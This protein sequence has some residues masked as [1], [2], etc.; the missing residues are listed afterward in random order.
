MNALG[1]DWISVLLIAFTHFLVATDRAFSKKIRREFQVALCMC[2]VLAILDNSYLN[3][4]A[5]TGN[6]L[7]LLIAGFGAFARTVALAL[8][9]A[10]VTPYKKFVNY[11][12]Y[13][14]AVINFVL[15]CCGFILPCVISSFVYAICI[16]VFLFIDKSKRE[17]SDIVLSAFFGLT[18]VLAF[19]VEKEYDNK[20]VVN[21]C[22]TSLICIYYYYLVMKTYKKDRLTG[23]LI[24]HNLT[25]E[26]EDNF[27]RPYDLVLIDVDN[28]KLI[29]DKY[30]HDKGD[31]VLVTIVKTTLKHL[32]RGC[33]MY[34]FG[35][36]EF[37]IISRKVST[38]V[39]REA[40]EASNTELAEDDYRMS[41][42]IVKHEPGDDS[43][44]T[45]VN[46]DKAMYEN[47]RLIKSE[48]IWDDMT[49]LYNLRGF[50][51][52]LE[53]FRKSSAKENHSVCLVGVDVERLSNINKDYGYTE[54]NL[55]ITVLA[56]ALKSCLRGRDFIGHLGSDEFVVAIE[57][58]NE[59]DDYIVSFISQLQEMV[60]NSFELSSKEYFV[61]LN[62]DR[63]FIEIDSKIS[64][65]VHV[66]NLLYIKQ[67]E[68]DNRRKNDI[69]ETEKEYNEEEDA[70]VQSILDNNKL[71]YAFQPIVSARDGQ[72]LGYESLM[73]SDTET[74]VSPLTILKYADRSKRSYDVEK[75]TMF[76]TLAKF[77]ACT[78]I[79]EN[80]RIFVNAIPGHLLSD[81]DFELLKSKYGYLMGR[82]VVEITEQREIDDDSLARLNTRREKGGFNIAIDDYGSGVSNTNN[83]LRY[84]P[85]VV[86][87]DRLLITGIDRNAKKQ[88]F[89]KSIIAFAQ[90][91][92]MYTL[93]EGVETESELKAVIRLGVDLIQGY[94]AAKP[95]IDIIT[96]IPDNIRK[97][98]IKENL[99]AGENQ[100]MVYTAS[101]SCE[102][103]VV[104][105]AMEDY[106]QINVSAE[107]VTISGSSEFTADMIIKIKE[108]TDCH[109]TL[110]DVKLSSV[111]G[112]PC[113]E[114]EENVNLTLNIEGSCKLKI[115]GIHVP[116]S[117][118][119]KII[120]G[121]TLTIDAKGHEC[122]AIGT[123]TQTPFGL[124]ELRSS[125]LVTVNID[126]E[127][128]TGIGG[129]IKGSNSAIS[130]TSG[131]VNLN[132][133]GVNAVGI[134]AH[135]GDVPIRICNTDMNNVFRANSGTVIGTLE[136]NQDIVFENFS[137]EFN[138]SGT[139]ISVIGTTG[140]A[141]GK[142]RLYAG[143]IK[144][145]FSGHNVVFIGGAEGD[146]DIDISHCS[147]ITH[148]EGD[149]ISGFG[150]RS[151]EA[152]LSIIE[153]SVDLTINASSPYAIGAKEKNVKFIGP[154]KNFDINGVES[155]I[156]AYV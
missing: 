74:M 60:D 43:S 25:F 48:D 58:D 11:F 24:R 123:D 18:F 151:Q 75:L 93:A 15:I 140:A 135:K 100:R 109:L 66:N 57:C 2:L 134:G 154:S 41:Y 131:T 116:E 148:G 30:G 68:K 122:F 145:K 36:D 5:E 26:L 138:G 103:S 80:V 49:G 132:V 33:R 85:Q 31:E 144:S 13:I 65:E 17:V 121:G 117:S 110:S 19:V 128:C 47:K 97:L 71:Q 55:I 98:I 83:L 114:L 10:I 136:G 91:N 104:Q 141:T 147:I 119:I 56:K 51:D 39:L 79:P 6:N 94:V 101:E 4:A 86:K 50:L 107:N 9:A 42:G 146:I 142:V 82:M 76:N 63:Y 22:L 124:I 153:C 137:I 150:T 102:L 40:I 46:A 84:M 156:F 106:T 1:F 127:E 72:I 35:G 92:D 115:K 89:V 21:G 28:F 90:E 149:N 52:E 112:R 45:I 152:I 143:S 77:A 44:V 32:P 8:L 29:N 23:L 130:L 62:I 78:E 34:R 53:S 59:E 14:P 7:F 20:T 126:G 73:R 81:V 38:E 96:E 67:D 61:K 16:I 70:L 87:I 155:D 133:A 108:N 54:G 113:I 118:S 88:F 129:G 37:I 95:S 105:L 27:N 111:D 139:N 64:S 99:K 120:G 125:G 3:S 69:S 12:V